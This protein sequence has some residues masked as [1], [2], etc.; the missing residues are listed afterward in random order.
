MARTELLF[1][2]GTLKRGFL[3]HDHLANASCRGRYETVVP[4]P[5]VILA[6]WEMP[7]LYNRPGQGQR[8]CGE[9]YE[10]DP[11]TL[12]RIDVLE[13]V[14]EP[15]G[16][17]RARIRLRPLDPG[18]AP[19]SAWTY[20]KCGTSPELARGPWLRE[21]QSARYRRDDPASG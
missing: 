15:D 21:Y 9:L 6:P 7:S 19:C 18:G 10:V 16:Y 3:N 2:Y 1:V 12:R 11:P 14:G 8:V 17:E 4:H 13:M 5:L 20:F